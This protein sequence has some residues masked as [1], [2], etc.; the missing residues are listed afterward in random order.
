MIKN[1]RI[2]RVLEIVREEKYITVEKLVNK[3]H[4]SPAT[5]RRDLTYLAELGLI[6]KSY[7]GVSFSTGRPALVREH[8]N[9]LEKITI[10]K[11]A[12]E[13]INDGDYVFIDGTTTTYFLGEKIIKKKDVT[14]CTANLKLA[15]FLCE[16]GVN[17]YVCGGKVYDAIMTGGSYVSDMIEKFNFNVAFFAVSSVSKE[18]YVAHSEEYWDYIKTAIRNSEKSVLLCDSDKLK[19]KSNRYIGDIGIFDIMITNQDVSKE[20]KNKFENVEFITAKY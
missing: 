10:C 15:S 11:R 16:H 19:M 3:L 6:K 12:S 5:I 18:G 1:E 9:T 13:M 7:G 20:L 14:V 4:Y 8:E 2:D 17:C